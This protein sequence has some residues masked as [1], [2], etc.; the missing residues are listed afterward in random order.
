MAFM[1]EDGRGQQADVFYDRIAKIESD[2][3][4]DR[5][6]LLGAVMAH[7]LGHLLLG[8]HAHTATGITQARWDE[9]AVQKVA[10][11]LTGFDVEQSGRI[12][13]RVGELEQA[14]RNVEAPEQKQGSP[15]MQQSALSS[16]GLVLRAEP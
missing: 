15:A 16:K 13:K 4:R 9:E 5:A 7:E 1:G 11:G 6:V 3:A 14:A 12:R 2:Q 8:P 10:Q